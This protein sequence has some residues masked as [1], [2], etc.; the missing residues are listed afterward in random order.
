ML[1]SLEAR[2]N[3]ATLITHTKPDLCHIHSI[4]TQISP[5]ILDT[6][7]DQHVPVVMTVHDHH[8]VSPQYNIWAPGCGK[9]YRDVGLVRGSLSRYH[10]HSLLGSF[11]QTF[12]YKVHRA[13]RIY[14]RGV[15]MFICPSQYMKRQLVLGGFSESK[16]RVVPFGINARL[17]EPRY[18]RGSYFL[19]VGRLS[20]EKGIETIVH[21]AG[22]LPDLVFKIVG[23]G[24]RM[25]HLHRLAD[26]LANVEFLGYRDGEEL[27]DLYRGTRAV[28][29]PSRVHENFPLTILEAMA[30]GKPVIGS[31]VGGVPEII[32]DCING[33][34][35]APTDLRGWV[36]A[37]M[38][39]AYDDELYA[40][41]SRE[42]RATVEERFAAE[43]H[44]QRLM[45][46]YNGVI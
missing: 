29:L 12:A 7:R 32:Q 35:V 26:G 11:A 38:R 36:E 42:A 31:N 13:L 44:Y 45:E 39:L 18:N 19:F 43:D 21:A 20:E 9:D 14:G 16:I 37:I 41:L 25:E 5:S 40:R 4:Y 28:V 8:L 34:L 1:Y 15:D 3:L 23:R 24:P 2:R 30:I 10:K 46:I 22:L 17:L 33:F 6:L 27:R